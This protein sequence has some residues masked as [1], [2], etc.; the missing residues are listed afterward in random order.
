MSSLKPDE[1]LARSF[2]GAMAAVRRLRGRESHRPGELSDAQYSLLFCLRSQPAMPTSELADLADLSP[3]S[4]TEMLDGMEDAGLVVRER[5]ERDRR[6]VLTSLTERGS[7]LVEARRARY[8]PRW[9]AAL[10]EFTEEELVVA[11]TVLDRLRVLFDELVI[12]KTG[13]AATE[14]R[15]A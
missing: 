5:S 2:K 8:E 9:R 10:D 6:V 13:A 4:T 14:E 12:E 7:E 3:A 1:Q 11:A 15:A